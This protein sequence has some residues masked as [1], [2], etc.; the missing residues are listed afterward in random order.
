MPSPRDDKML[1]SEEQH[2]LEDELI[3]ARNRVP[4]PN[5]SNGKR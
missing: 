5:A 3:A 4:M 1:T 2:Q